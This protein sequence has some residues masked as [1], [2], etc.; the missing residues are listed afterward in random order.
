MPRGK[1]SMKVDELFTRWINLPEAQRRIQQALDVARRHQDP[2]VVLRGVAENH[3]THSPRPPS[4]NSLPSPRSDTV[5]RSNSFSS[6]EHAMKCLTP[7]HTAPT[8]SL[9]NSH[10]PAFYFPCGMPR[11]DNGLLP[12]LRELKRIFGDVGGTLDDCAQFCDVVQIPRTWRSLLAYAAH[13]DQNLDIFDEQGV[14]VKNVPRSAIEKL[15]RDAYQYTD[16]N[17]L[18]IRLVAGEDND[19]FLDDDGL[20]LFVLDLIQTVPSLK[21][22]QQSKD[23]HVPYAR[24]VIQRL[25][26]CARTWTNRIAAMALRRSGFL[27]AVESIVDVD[28]DIN[29]ECNF[30]SYEHFYVIYCKFWELDCAHSM[31]I[32]I[33]ELMRYGD[34]KINPKVFERLGKATLRYRKDRMDY[35]DFVW[36]ILAEEDKANTTSHEYWFRILDQDGD[37]LISMFDLYQFYMEQLE[38]L[39]LDGIETISFEDKLDEVLDRLGAAT[40]SDPF[41]LS[42]GIRLATLKSAKDV[43][44]PILDTFLNVDKYLISESG[45]QADPEAGQIETPWQRFASLTYRMLVEDD[46]DFEENR[47]EL[48]DHFLG[49]DNGY[50]V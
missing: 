5:R 34:S 22:L 33:P 50:H 39:R 19:M 42:K 41:E 13:R 18:F 1:L 44:Q 49:G 46:G 48:L 15:W 38:R 37:G 14:M 26:Y 2:N 36:F 25:G 45:E 35:A 17:A 32:S 9:H 20:L 27:K 28:S 7:T 30:F 11:S 24:T 12:H 10:I 21:F 43:A 40:R 16:E 29:A 23:F 4:P 3:V 47:D 31:S 8:Q 6:T